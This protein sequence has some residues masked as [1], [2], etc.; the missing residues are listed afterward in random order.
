[1]GRVNCKYFKN[2]L[3][4]RRVITLFLRSNYAKYVSL[5][6]HKEMPTKKIEVPKIVYKINKSLDFRWEKKNTES[7]IYIE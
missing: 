4:L 2:I 7:K 6:F 1:M 3:I 5:N